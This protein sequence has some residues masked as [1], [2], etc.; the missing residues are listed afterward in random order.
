MFDYFDSNLD[1]K[2]NFTKCL[3]KAFGFVLV[4]IPPPNISQLWFGLNRFHQN[5]LTAFGCGKHS[6]VK[7]NQTLFNFWN[8][9]YEIGWLTV[10]SSFLLHKVCIS[11]P[12]LANL[13]GS[14]P[15]YL[16]SFSIPSNVD[17]AHWVTVVKFRMRSGSFVLFAMGKFTIGPNEQRQHFTV[18]TESRYI[19]SEFT[20]PKRFA[21]FGWRTQN[22]CIKKREK[23]RSAELGQTN[24]CTKVNSQ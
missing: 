3:K 1:V 6:W 13:L 15:L 5:C 20:A 14:V 9:K 11:Y 16:L 12:N 8:F 4:I 22:F 24:Y 23:K 17:F 19:H 18:Q 2:N 7:T 10:F 21:K